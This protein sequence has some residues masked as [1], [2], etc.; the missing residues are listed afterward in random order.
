[1]FVFFLDIFL[2]VIERRAAIQETDYER[3]GWTGMLI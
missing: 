1:M 2:L 3:L